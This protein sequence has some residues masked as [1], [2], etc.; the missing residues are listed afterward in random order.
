MRK[1]TSAGFRKCGSFWVLKALS[2]SYWLL[3]SGE[4]IKFINFFLQFLPDYIHPPLFHS[5]T[6]SLHSLTWPY[7]LVS[8][9][10]WH[11]FQLSFPPSQFFTQVVKLSFHSSS[12]PSPLHHSPLRWS[13]INGGNHFGEIWFL[14][15]GK[16]GDT[17]Q[18]QQ[19]CNNLLPAAHPT[20]FLRSL[21]IQKGQR[22]LHIPR[23]NSKLKK[24]RISDFLNQP[25]FDNKQVHVSS[26]CKKCGDWAGN[27]MA[28]RGWRDRAHSGPES[29]IGRSGELH[30]VVI[31]TIMFCTFNNFHFEYHS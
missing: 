16:C 6:H 11:F 30:C 31:C 22:Y 24:K 9:K 25:L 13:L 28:Q 15:P 12:L 2:Q 21:G 4:K 26:D 10:F 29:G 3:K 27:E 14:S 18:S 5:C 1:L 7:L 17:T 20:A 8:E 19:Y 23:L